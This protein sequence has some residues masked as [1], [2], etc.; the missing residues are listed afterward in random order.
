MSSCL[1]HRSLGPQLQLGRLQLGSRGLGVAGE[2]LLATLHAQL[3]AGG[4]RWDARGS[5][6]RKLAATPGA[7]G[8]PFMV[9][10]GGK[11]RGW[12]HMSFV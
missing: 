5:G 6:G 7:W 9:A 1:T 2:R 3:Y 4:G 11:L 10:I 8:S 12:L